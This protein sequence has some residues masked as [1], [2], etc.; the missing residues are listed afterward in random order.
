MPSAWWSLG[1]E[2][3]TY[4]NELREAGRSEKMT[5]KPYRWSLRRMFG[6]LQNNGFTVNPRKVGRAELE[7]LRDVGIGG[8]NRY[9]ANMVKIMLGFL[10][11]AGNKEAAKL[12]M[13]F[14]NTSPTNIRWLEDAQANKVRMYAQGDTKML[15]HCELDMGMRRVEVLRLKVTDFLPGPVWRVNLLGKG[16]NGGKPRQIACHPE[17]PQVLEE[18]LERR[19]ALIERAKRKNPDVVVPDALL[20]YERGGRLHAYKKTAVDKM[21]TKLGE[22]VG[23]A[24]SNHDLRRSF[25]RMMYRAGVKIEEIARIFGHSDM[26]TTMR[27]LGL[28]MEDMSNAMNRLASY[29]A[30]TYFPKTETNI[31]SQEKSGQSGI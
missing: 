6:I 16:R 3:E 10:K 9:R 30:S 23:F 19:N 27:Y 26:R 7:F 2:I 18:H 29:Q 4:L 15:V 21:L 31:L 5:I 22:Q 14:G 17:T 13:G 28:D 12:K 20:I 1:K 25:G 11:F 24:F 8:T